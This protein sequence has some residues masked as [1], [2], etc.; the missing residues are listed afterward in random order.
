MLTL[1]AESLGGFRYGNLI[2]NDPFLSAD[3]W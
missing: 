2:S 3:P 1:D